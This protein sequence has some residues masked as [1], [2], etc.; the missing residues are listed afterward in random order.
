MK[1]ENFRKLKSEWIT[2]QTSNNHVWLVGKKTWSLEGKPTQNERSLKSKQTAN[3]AKKMFWEK[4]R[5]WEREKRRSKNSA[6][7][8]NTPNEQAEDKTLKT[9][10]ILKTGMVGVN[11]LAWCINAYAYVLTTTSLIWPW[12]WDRPRKLCKRTNTHY[13]SFSISESQSNV[14]YVLR[15]EQTI[16]NLNDGSSLL[17][18]RCSDEYIYWLEEKG[19]TA[20]KPE[21]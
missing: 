10:V 7:T 5:R 20:R 14:H 1:R 3:K 9:G 21:D 13:F 6:F 12:P 4:E 15:T 8:K 19:K 11:T 18:K 2:E 17:L 16:K